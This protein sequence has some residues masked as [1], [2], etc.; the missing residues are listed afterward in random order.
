MGCG[1]LLTLMA[2][3]GHPKALVDLKVRSMGKFH[4]T[5]LSSPLLFR[6]IWDRPASTPCD[7]HTRQA[8]G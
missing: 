2:M 3:R 8:D 6:A 1:L 5:V 7:R 4:T